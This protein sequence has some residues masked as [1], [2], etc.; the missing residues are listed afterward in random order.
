MAHFHQTIVKS[1]YDIIYE[2]ICI[3]QRGIVINIHGL[4]RNDN[5]LTSLNNMFLQFDIEPSIINYL[6][7]CEWT[8]IN[9]LTY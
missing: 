8:V 3:D 2:Y 7:K 4:E 5:F 6:I 9:S 1:I